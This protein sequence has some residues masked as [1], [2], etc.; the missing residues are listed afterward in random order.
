MNLFGTALFESCD[1]LCRLLGLAPI[2]KRQRS[3]RR[4]LAACCSRF[5]QPM[6]RRSVEASLHDRLLLRFFRLASRHLGRCRLYGLHRSFRQSHRPGE[7]GGQNSRSAL[8]VLEHRLPRCFV[9]TRISVKC[10]SSSSKDSIDGILYIQLSFQYRFTAGIDIRTELTASR[11]SRRR[12]K[13]MRMAESM[14][15]LVTPASPRH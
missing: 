1:S 7:N 4:H 12:V 15:A 14:M 6:C 3:C 5:R 10:L 11:D 8:S 2:S 13:R 9:V